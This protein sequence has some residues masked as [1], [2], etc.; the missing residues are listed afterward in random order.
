MC[1]HVSLSFVFDSDGSLELIYDT[2]DCFITFEMTI[3]HCRVKVFLF[4]T[5]FLVSNLV[6]ALYLERT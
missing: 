3:K 2:C 5:L 1:I 4:Q 6:V